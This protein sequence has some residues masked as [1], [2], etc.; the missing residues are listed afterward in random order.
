ME[1]ANTA[2]EKT[3]EDH[4]NRYIMLNNLG[5]TLGKRYNRMSN[6]DDLNRAI[7]AFSLALK[8]VSDHHIHRPAILGNLGIKTLYTI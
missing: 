4:P 6:V 3:P 8:C 1:M 2:V 5:Y 7:E